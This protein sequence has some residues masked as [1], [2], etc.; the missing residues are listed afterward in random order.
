VCQT[1]MIGLEILPERLISKEVPSNAIERP[2][3]STAA[4]FARLSEL[5]LNRPYWK[6]KRAIDFVVALSVAIMLLPL[7]AAVSVLVLIDVGVPTVFWQQRLGRNGAPLHL[8]KFRTLQTLFDRATK[9]RREA[10]KSRGENGGATNQVKTHSVLI[11]CAIDQ[12]RERRDLCS[13]AA[14][15]RTH[16]ALLRAKV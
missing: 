13:F 8:Y 10:K 16:C 2:S 11:S 15:Q 9:E 3:D 4:I 7:I 5:K 1:L 12:V 14:S 6:L